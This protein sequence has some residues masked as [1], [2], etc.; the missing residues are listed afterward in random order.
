MVTEI[1]ETYGFQNLIQGRA[2]QEKKE[3]DLPNTFCCMFDAD[4]VWDTDTS[5]SFESFAALIHG[6]AIDWKTG[7]QQF[8]SLHSADLEARTAYTSVKQGS[9]I[10]DILHKIHT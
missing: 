9:L 10:Q 2:W 8:I 5:R 1:H 3:I 7:Q 4:N 6:I